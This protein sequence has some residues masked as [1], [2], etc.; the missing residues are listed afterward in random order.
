MRGQG[1]GAGCGG[2]VRG[3]G[4]GAGCGAAQGP[5]HAGV[6]AAGQRAA[7]AA[8]AGAAA[9]AHLRVATNPATAN[10]VEQQLAVRQGVC[11]ELQRA[12]GAGDWRPPDR[13]LLDFHHASWAPTPFLPLLMRCCHHPTRA[14]LAPAKQALP[15]LLATV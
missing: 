1:A 6:W 3:Q 7:V 2:R 10:I 12:A 15:T 9:A 11:R 8:A 5:Q 14:L 13:G 4:A